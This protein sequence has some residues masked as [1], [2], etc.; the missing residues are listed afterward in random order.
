MNDRLHLEEKEKREM[1][2]GHFTEQPWQDEKTNLM[3]ARNT[4]LDI[5]NRLYDPEPPAGR[6]PRIPE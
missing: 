3:G 1:L 5:S 2:I 6:D 4:T